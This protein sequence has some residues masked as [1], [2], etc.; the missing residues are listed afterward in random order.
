MGRREIGASVDMVDGDSSGDSDGNRGGV[1]VAAS[2]KTDDMGK[3][4]CGA[5]QR[6]GRHRVTTARCEEGPTDMGRQST[7]QISYAVEFKI[8][9]RIFR[10]DLGEKPEI[11]VATKRKTCSAYKSSTGLLLYPAED[12]LHH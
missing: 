2:A 4:R 7:C 11:G 6:P 12:V 9:K 8:Q 10:H 5:A 3:V 1:R